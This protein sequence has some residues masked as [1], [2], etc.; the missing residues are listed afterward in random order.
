MQFSAYKKTLWPKCIAVIIFIAGFVNILSAIFPTHSP[1]LSILAEVVPLEVFNATRTLTAISGILLFILASGVWSQKHRAWTLSIL[2]IC[3]SLFTHILRRESF[4]EIFCLLVPLFL[5]IVFRHDFHVRSSK[6][7]LLGRLKNFA[8]IVSM[9]LVYMV[10]GFFVLNK[11][12]SQPVTPQNFGEN[13]QYTVTGLGRD[14]LIPRTHR[15]QW[16]EDSLLT[17]SLVIIALAFASF[18]APFIQDSHQSIEE[19]AKVREL[20]EMYGGTSVSY[21]SLLD[22]KKYFFTGQNQEHGDGYTG[23]IAYGTTTGTAVALGEPF[24]PVSEFPRV[25]QEFTTQMLECGL[26]CVF[27][28]ITETHRKIFEKLGFSLLKVGEEAILRPPHFSLEGSEMK[29]VRNSIAHVKKTGSKFVWYPLH[30][31]PWSLKNEIDTLHREWLEQHSF[32]QLSFSVDFF[33]LPGEEKGFLAVSISATGKLEAALSFLPYGGGRNLALD[34]MLRAEHSPNGVVE[35]LLAESV[36]FF[37][38]HSIQR[39][40]LGLV[41]LAN[42]QPDSVTAR[43]VQVGRSMLFKHFNQ[44][45]NYQSLFLF[46]NKFQPT[47]EPRYVAYTNNAEVLKVAI[48]LVRIHTRQ[49]LWQKFTKE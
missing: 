31:L 10:A 16:F 2:V 23:V 17:I 9:L 13:Y 37:Q 19:I 36:L 4:G 15:A 34:A 11:Q 38:K 22:D 27:Y 8:L 47:W 32:P 40:S 46:K 48:A 43:L 14:T 12:F 21:F 42:T 29:K 7:D 1:I 18:F 5:L 45:Y 41:A 44:F 6:V 33:P 26:S 49:N 20:L 24:A 35:A 25:I 30:Q 3:F 39:M 28:L